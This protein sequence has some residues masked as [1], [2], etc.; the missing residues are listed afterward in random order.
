[1]KIL[2]ASPVSMTNYEN[3]LHN[4]GIECLSTLDDS[5]CEEFD[6]LLIPG[7]IDINPKLYGEDIDGTEQYDDN[8]DSGQINLLK[9]FTDLRKPVLGICRGFQLINVFFGGSLY[10]DIKNHRTGTKEDGHHSVSSVKGSVFEEIMGSECVVNTAHHQAAK[11]LGKG[12][13]IQQISK[14]GLV[15]AVI[16]EDLPVIAVQYHPERMTLGFLRDDVA[17]G[18]KVFDYFVKV[19]KKEV[20]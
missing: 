20:C 5:G 11:R 6:A 1:M 19:I 8:L 18:Q 12:L 14:D 15:E 4:M 2:I 16:H 13:I 10:Q 17:D 7:G 3:V 9:K